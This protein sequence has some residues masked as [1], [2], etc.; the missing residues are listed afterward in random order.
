M[1]VWSVDIGYMSLILNK[2]CYEQEILGGFI[3]T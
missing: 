2:G 3:L 1:R